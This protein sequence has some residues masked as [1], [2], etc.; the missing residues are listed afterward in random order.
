MGAAE[1]SEGDDRLCGTCTGDRQVMRLP[2]HLLHARTQTLK[3]VLR[4]GRAAV[5][6]VLEQ[7]RDSPKDHRDARQG[8]GNTAWRGGGKFS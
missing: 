2:Q 5:Y 8:S 7:Q 3:A 1:S 6:S 4:C